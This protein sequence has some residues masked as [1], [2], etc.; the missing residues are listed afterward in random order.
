[1]T[2]VADA[3]LRFHAL[4][5]CALCDEAR[6]V[7]AFVGQD[8]LFGLP[9]RFPYRSCSACGTVFQDPQVA[10]DDVARLYP[11]AYYTHAPGSAP[12][13]AGR[14][15]AA[16]RDRWRDALRASIRGGGGR[17][18]RW[19]ARSRSLRE[20]AFFGL[21]DELIPRANDRRALE[22]G[23]GAGDLLALLSRAGWPE[24]EGVD[25]DAAAAAVAQARSARTVRVGAFP[26]VELPS[27][28]YDLVVLVHV[29]EHLP[30]PRAVLE[31]LRT[32]LTRN[33][34]AVVIG[35]NPRSLG[36]RLF[37][38]F[39]VEWDPPR[40][41]VL[42]PLAALAA[43]AARAGLR[44]ARARTRTR[45][46]EKFTW[47]RAARAGH[48]PGKASLRDRLWST[49]GGALAAAGAEAGEEMVLVLERAE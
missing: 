37:G 4:G 27:E 34:R 14:G 30:R 25:F 28:A 12:A 21:T 29:F 44:P 31:R 48:E 35:P 47:S 10:A 15:L 41:L 2:A 43:A 7:E 33:G 3:P 46:P 6:T 26:D 8:R 40:H 39:W 23:P 36:A 38:P 42:P 9:G 17:P 18:A 45:V 24:V 11:A 20:R 16:A 32:L 19:L 49:L 1:M 22:V 5:R 13:A